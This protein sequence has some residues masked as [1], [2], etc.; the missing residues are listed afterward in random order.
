M[1]KRI[2]SCFLAALLLGTTV[3]TPVMAATQPTN[4]EEMVAANRENVQ[5][6]EPYVDE[7]FNTIPIAEDPV[8]E[9]MEEPDGVSENSLSENDITMEE[10]II[11]SYSGDKTLA[12]PSKFT[13]ASQ[14]RNLYSY[15][16]NYSFYQTA[17]SVTRPYA[18]GTLSTIH[19]QKAMESVNMMRMI[20]GLPSV[21]YNPAYTSQ[22]QQGAVILAANNSLDN[23]P[24]QPSGM[25][26]NFYVSGRTA[27]QKS[28][29]ASG[30]FQNWRSL[31]WFTQNFME[32]KA[33]GN[34]AN[35]GHRRWILNPRMGSTGFGYAT[36]KSNMAYALI[37]VDDSSV[38]PPDYDFISWPS[39]GNFPQELCQGDTP[40]SVSL[41]PDKFDVSRMNLNN[42]K[43]SLTLPNGKIQKFTAADNGTDRFD[44][45]KPYFNVNFEAAGESNAIIFK[46]GTA[47]CG[48]GNLSGIYN[49]TIT[50]I[51]DRQGNP[52]TISYNVEFFNA[53][54]YLG[55]VDDQATSDTHVTSFV[56]RLYTLCFGRQPDEGG[57]LDWKNSLVTKR[58]SGADVAYGFFFSPEL[59]NR[60]LSDRE[61]VDLCYKVLLDRNADPNGSAYWLSCMR[62]GVTREGVFKG[63]AES[64]EFNDLC[65]SYGITRGT[66]KVTQGRDRNP[67]LTSFITRMY[68][69]ALGRGYDIGG[70]NDWC[71]RILDKKWSVTDAATTGFFHSREFLDKNLSNAEYIKVLYRTFLGREYDI[72]GFYD[73]LNKLDSGKMTRDQ[74]LRGFSD[75]KE[76]RNIMKEYGL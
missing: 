55:G 33:P 63:F 31:A 32:D 43:V 40:W 30:S 75:S 76:F 72:Q 1:R 16:L 52:A 28:N 38:L 21:N 42:V 54:G 19:L 20:A 46:P 66:V 13:I 36:N 67:G 64:K 8:E 50:G 11:Y 2:V 51:K 27:T 47:T 41:N 69:K 4:D 14:Y 59:K 73:W 39:S 7:A 45:S 49:V 65:V 3:T 15:G 62:D 9:S 44:I 23:Y 22:A 57:M 37:Y 25:D 71:N 5:L 10:E 34:L 18:A 60:N 70:L 58:R 61:F 68:T 24:S 53:A 26:T 48:T 56:T 74:V 12:K 29:I 6:G 35:V 17:P